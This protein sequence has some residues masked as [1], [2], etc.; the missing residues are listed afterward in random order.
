MKKYF[1]G[2]IAIVGAITFSAFTPKVN[3]IDFKLGATP[4]TIGIVENQSQWSPAGNTY[5]TCSV[6]SNE[7][8]CRIIIDVDQAIMSKYYDGSNV[9]YT[10][11]DASADKSQDKRYLLITATKTGNKAEISSIVPHKFVPD[12]LGGYNDVVDTG[13]DV[14]P[15]SAT[16]GANNEVAFVNGLE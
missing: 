5:G 9:L 14:N 10:L 7:I 16:L 3:P 1:L 6:V 12:G 4:T 15:N 11:A 13:V 2:L 8:A